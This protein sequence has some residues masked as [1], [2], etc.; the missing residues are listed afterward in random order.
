MP[1]F[2]GRI[3]SKGNGG[4]SGKRNPRHRGTSNAPA[5]MRETKSRRVICATPVRLGIFDSVYVK[6]LQACW[7]LTS[8]AIA[9]ELF[10]LVR[11]RRARHCRT[12]APV[13]GKF[14]VC[15][16]LVSRSF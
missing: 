14:L 8:G 9:D 2:S 12:E 4:T 5:I 3:S 10:W 15:F 6:P 1:L 11:R 7:V 13:N 16:F